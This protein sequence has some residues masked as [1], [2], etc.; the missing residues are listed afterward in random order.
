[1]SL[2]PSILFVAC[3]NIDFCNPGSNL[4]PP[5]QGPQPEE[6][7]VYIQRWTGERP[8]QYSGRFSSIG[9]KCLKFF[10]GYDP[11]AL[12]GS[13]LQHPSLVVPPRHAPL[14]CTSL[15]RQADPG[16]AGGGKE[17]GLLTHKKPKDLGSSLDLDF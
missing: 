6:G 16:Y 2:F 14:S 8:H 15:L 11:G 7:Q 10:L 13:E 9:K 4:G 1:M 5:L 12:S 3:K 17:I